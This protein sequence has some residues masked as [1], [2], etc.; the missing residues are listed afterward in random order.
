MKHQRIAACLHSAIVREVSLKHKPGLVEPDNTGAHQDMDYNLFLKSAEAIKP[1]L[2][3]MCEIAS[4]VQEPK[5]LFLALKQVGIQAEQEMFEATEGINTH[6]GMIFNMALLSGATLQ[7]LSRFGT[8]DYTWMQNYIQKMTQGLCQRELGTSVTSY[9][10]RLYKAYGI[11]G[12]RG[13]AEA[14]YPILFEGAIHE[15]KRIKNFYEDEQKYLH[16]MMYLMEHIE[17][18]NII[19]RHDPETLLEVQAVAAQFRKQYPIIHEPAIKALDNLNKTFVKRHI[20]PGGTA[21]TLAMIIFIDEVSSIY[22][23]SKSRMSIQA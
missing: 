5:K 16:L 12:I 1:Y 19:A 13:Q 18:T 14:G 11:T 7:C 20:S 22:S 10:E 6:K 2:A 4:S 8:L 3:K 9:G 17:D 15:L 21:D 23:E